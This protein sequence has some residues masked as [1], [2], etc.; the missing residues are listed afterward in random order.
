MKKN[1]AQRKLVTVWIASVATLS[2]LTS[3]DNKNSKQKK[4][5]QVDSDGSNDND[6]G[7]DT[8]QGSENPGNIANIDKLVKLEGSLSLAEIRAKIKSGDFKVSYAI[9]EKL[10]DSYRKKLSDYYA[11]EALQDRF[12]RDTVTFE[13]A[14]LKDYEKFVAS[15]KNTAN[16]KDVEEIKANLSASSL[17]KFQACEKEDASACVTFFIAEKASHAEVLYLS[18]SDKNKAV[19]FTPSG[20]FELETEVE[21]PEESFA[22]VRYFNPFTKEYSGVYHSSEESGE[23]IPNVGVLKGKSIS[24]GVFSKAI[25]E[26]E[27]LEIL[28][29]K[30]QEIYY[31]MVNPDTLGSL[32][33]NQIQIAKEVEVLAGLGD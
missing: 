17:K 10:S 3:C 24:D 23:T 14:I 1:Y 8:D 6:N 15:V 29:L 18:S 27:A 30:I 16:K 21:F 20:L 19:Y 32:S 25:L 33:Q 9:D 2:V 7:N 26:D 28:Q 4:N 12:D 22:A 5:K 11:V 31:G 13:D